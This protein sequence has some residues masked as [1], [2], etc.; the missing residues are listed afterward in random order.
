MADPG[1]VG[2]QGGR[3]FFDQHVLLDSEWFLA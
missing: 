3:L 1:L 2:G